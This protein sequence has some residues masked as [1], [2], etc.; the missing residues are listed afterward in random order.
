MRGGKDRRVLLFC[1][2][3]VVLRQRAAWCALVSKPQ[4][5]FFFLGKIGSVPPVCLFA[6]F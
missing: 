5:G 1:L 6:A 2:I 4:G 3:A